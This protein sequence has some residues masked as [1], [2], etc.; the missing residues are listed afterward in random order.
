MLYKKVLHLNKKKV[1]FH[2]K[3]F[4]VDKNKMILYQKSIL[5]LKNLLIFSG[6]APRIKWLKTTC[7]TLP[8]CSCIIKSMNV[9]HDEFRRRPNSMCTFSLWTQKGRKRA[10][11]GG[12]TQ[13]NTLFTQK[14]ITKIIRNQCKASLFFL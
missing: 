9:L 3:V 10:H 2:K 1:T 7:I 4:H 12:I 11:I 5:C 8:R 6:T 14:S 13:S